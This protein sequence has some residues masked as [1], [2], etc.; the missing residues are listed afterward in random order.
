MKLTQEINKVIEWIAEYFNKSEVSKKAII[1][2]SGGIDSA[3]IA[4]LC[5]NAIGRTNVIGAILPCDSQLEDKLDAI[6]ICDHLEIPHVIADLEQTFLTWWLMYRNEIGWP[7]QEAEDMGPIN[8]LIPA[9]TKARLRMITLYAIAGQANGL[10]IG[11][12]NK[13]EA[14]LGYATK[15]GDGGVDIEPIMDF[16]KTEIFEMAKILKIPCD[17][18]DKAPSA[19]LWAGQTDEKELGMTYD[20]IDTYLKFRKGIINPDK[21]M[22]RIHME[23]IDDL[24]S[25]NKHKNINLPYYKR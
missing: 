20:Q 16:Y 8:R 10:V 18:I 11:T 13:T 3:V 21:T 15:Y 17:I 23:I 1:G 14:K 7:C 12:T 24:I 9:N 22:K 4:N 5:V 6:K 2:I 19:G 25:A